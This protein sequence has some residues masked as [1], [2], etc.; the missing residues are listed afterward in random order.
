VWRLAEWI[1]YDGGESQNCDRE[2]WQLVDDDGEI[3]EEYDENSLDAASSYNFWEGEDQG[4]YVNFASDNG[5]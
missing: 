2:I 5:G 4:Q 1:L 3:L